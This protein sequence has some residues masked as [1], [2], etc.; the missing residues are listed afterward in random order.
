MIYRAA[1]GVRRLCGALVALAL[2]SLAGGHAL[3]DPAPSLVFVDGSAATLSPDS[4][5]VFRLDLALKNSGGA[6]GSGS[7]RVLDER[8]NGCDKSATTAVEK[9]APGD[10]T[11]VHIEIANVMLPATCYVVLKTDGGD[12]SLKEIKLSQQYLTSAILTPLR[13]C[14]WISIVVAGVAWLAAGVLLG[15]MAPWFM[16][17]SP[18][19]DFTKSWTSTTTLVGGI[20]STALT[21]SA[22]PDLTRYA[23]KAGYSA[24]ALLISLAV[25]VAPFVYVALRAGCIEKDAAAKTYTVVYRG[26][27]WA[28]LL[29][30]ALTLFAGLAQLSVLSVLL[31]EVF[32]GYRF[33]SFTTEGDPWSANAGSIATFVMGAVLCWYAGYS[34]YLTVKLQKQADSDAVNLKR[35]RQAAD[36]TLAATEGAPETAKGPLLSWP[37]L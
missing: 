3:A 36:H 30:C 15:G 25:V 4:S 1:G 6:G 18:A 26:C 9:L 19:W 32:R 34:M 12:S 33:W 16:L 17:G 10:V 2:C 13:V 8:D 29:S 14:F 24:L 21:L 23:S 20:L 31:H 35:V 28:F 11:V 27:L 5:N 37:V 22:L 7:L